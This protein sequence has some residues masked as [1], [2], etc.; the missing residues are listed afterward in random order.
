MDWRRMI[1]KKCREEH[2]KAKCLRILRNF[3]YG[4][5]SDTKFHTGVAEKLVGRHIFVANCCRGCVR[6]SWDR[7]VAC[8]R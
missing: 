8:V 5:V 4:N 7:V 6:G 1:H 2:R 3:F